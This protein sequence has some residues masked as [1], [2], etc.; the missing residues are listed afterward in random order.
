MRLYCLHE[1]FA[2]LVDTMDKT[3]ATLTKLDNKTPA[4]Q[5][6]LASLDTMRK[7]ILELNRKSIFFNEFKYRRRLSGLYFEVATSLETLSASK[8]GS[9]DVLEKEFMV[10]NNQFYGFLKKNR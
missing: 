10:F 3:I 1:K 5:V 9:I 6:A 4:N 7:E 2:V 8:E